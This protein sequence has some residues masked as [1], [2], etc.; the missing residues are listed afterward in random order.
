MSE[1]YEVRKL[2]SKTKI[3]F[4]ILSIF[5]ITVYVLQENTK[6]YEAQNILY[7]MGYNNISSLEVYGKKKVEDKLTKI[8]GTKYFVKF[9]NINTKQDCKGFILL[10]YK[11]KFA[12]DLSCE[13]GKK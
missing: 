6:E 2:P 7:S 5:A 4:I 8:Q 11:Q 1:T 13:K 3:I 12:Q 10:D 9:H